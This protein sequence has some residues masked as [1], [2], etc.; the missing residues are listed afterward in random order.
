MH[1][2]SYS[3]CLRRPH[4]AAYGHFVRRE[5]GRYLISFSYEDHARSHPYRS[6]HPGDGAMSLSPTRRSLRATCLSSLTSFMFT[7]AVL[8]APITARAQTV[9]TTPSRQSTRLNSSHSLT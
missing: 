8:G 4:A 7:C 2:G 9:V 6:R 5:R 1:K 3:S